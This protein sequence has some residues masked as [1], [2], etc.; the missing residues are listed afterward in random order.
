MYR[1]FRNSTAVIAAAVGLAGSA[2][3]QAPVNSVA[4]AAPAVSSLHLMPAGRQVPAA[5]TPGERD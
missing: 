5:V 2:A 3:A 4:P 1:M